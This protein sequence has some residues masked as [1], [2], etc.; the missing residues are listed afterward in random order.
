MGQAHACAEAEPPYQVNFRKIFLTTAS[1]EE[2]PNILM[3]H[4]T[5]PPTHPLPTTG[6]TTAREEATG[7]G[8]GC[9]RITYFAEKSYWNNIFV[10]RAD[11][12]TSAS[13]SGQHFDLTSVC[14]PCWICIAQGP[15]LRTHR[16][17]LL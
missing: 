3:S 8:G 9:R 2:K 17:P 7:G 4:P 16:W 15:V 11:G 10:V 1:W 13:L 14:F 5:V 12:H 6:Q